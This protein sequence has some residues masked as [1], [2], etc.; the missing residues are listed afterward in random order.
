MKVLI[1]GGTGTMGRYLVQFLAADKTNQIYI[2][3][4]H[5][6]H[7]EDRYV[8]Y[9]K[10]NAKES[11]FLS[12]LM[13]EYGKWDAIV[14]FMIYTADEFQERKDI[15]L[16]NTC[17]YVFLSSCRVYAESQAPIHEGSS[18][19]V[20]VVK[21][22]VCLDSNNYA[23][24][25]TKQE[26]LLYKNDFRNWTI[27]RPYI[28]YSSSKLQLGA[29]EKEEWLYRALHNRSIVFSE[30]MLDKATSLTFGKDVAQA[31]YCLLGEEKA[32]GDTFNITHNE[33]VT[34]REVLEVYVDCLQAAGYSGKVFYVG[35]ATKVSLNKGKVLYDRIYNRIFCNDKISGLCDCNSFISVK[36]GLPLCMGEFLEN[37]TFQNINWTTQARLD[38]IT[39]ECVHWHE[40][41]DFHSKLEYFIVRYL[42]S[43]ERYEKIR[44]VIARLH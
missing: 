38:R 9:I 25:K 31:I 2:T 35:E 14:D 7:S 8:H 5:A 28:T 19:L 44:N 34:W 20:D 30:D 27:V 43:Y 10:G 11:P 13:T 17:Q 42:L 22:E 4:R 39:K 15:I 37:P 29:Q 23:V 1:L 33:S 21:D 6:I 24:V 18:R 36:E 16:S 26:D 12:R 41:P 40:I 32:L 3:S